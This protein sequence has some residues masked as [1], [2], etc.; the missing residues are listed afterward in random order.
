M[1]DATKNNDLAADVPARVHEQDC[2]AEAWR[3]ADDIWS[4]GVVD[5]DDR[6]A[7][8]DD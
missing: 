8:D 3:E 7:D 2:W 4:D 1:T 6:G 5:T